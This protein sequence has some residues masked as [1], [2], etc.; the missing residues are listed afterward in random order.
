MEQQAKNTT[1]DTASGAADVTTDTS[2]GVATAAAD[3]AATG[4]SE[5]VAGSLEAVGGLLDVTGIGAG[6]GAVLGVAGLAVGAVEI[7]GDIVGAVE[8]SRDL[9]EEKA[10]QIA[11]AVK[12][13]ALNQIPNNAPSAG[14]F[15]IPSMNGASLAHLPSSMS[16]L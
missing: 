7:V 3:T 1:A 10:N 6:V 11:D 4:L 14:S 12:E 13:Q 5:T 16:H 15:V 8:K 9:V 2:S